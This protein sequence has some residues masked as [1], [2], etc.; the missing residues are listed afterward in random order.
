VA[1]A[2]LLLLYGP[3]AS[4]FLAGLLP[5]PALDAV[6]L[7]LSDGIGAWLAWLNLQGSLVQAQWQLL[8]GQLAS[9]P[10]PSPA[11]GALAPAAA[12]L[13]AVLLAWV[14]GNRALVTISLRAKT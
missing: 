10:A 5:T 3:Q 13:V 11:W 4:A 8:S 6:S 14:A 2:V 7:R 9:L 12:L 1:A